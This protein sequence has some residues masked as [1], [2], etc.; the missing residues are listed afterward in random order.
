MNDS[1][2]KMLPLLNPRLTNSRYGHE[3]VPDDG[4][5]DDDDSFDKVISEYEYCF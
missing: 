3:K 2:K 5:D 4:F 1:G